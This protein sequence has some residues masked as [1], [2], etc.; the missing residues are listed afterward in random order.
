MSRCMCLLDQSDMRW[1]V[2]STFYFDSNIFSPSTFRGNFGVN[3]PIIV[4]KNGHSSY[5]FFS[6]TGFGFLSAARFWSSLVHLPVNS[7]K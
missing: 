5:V 3:F 2:V 1:G 7:K 4:S 6:K